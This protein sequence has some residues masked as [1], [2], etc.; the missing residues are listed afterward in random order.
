MFVLTPARRP[1]FGFI[2]ASQGHSL[3]FVVEERLPA[4]RLDIESLLSTTQ[5]LWHGMQRANLLSILDNGL[6]PGGTKSRRKAVLVSNHA[7][8]HGVQCQLA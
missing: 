2:H 1:E 4:P 6:N 8:G 5:G 7:L 3:P